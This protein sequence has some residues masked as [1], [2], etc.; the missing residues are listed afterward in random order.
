[1]LDISP[2]PFQKIKPGREYILE[3]I[4]FKNKVWVE[5]KGRWLDMFLLVSLWI[6]FVLQCIVVLMEGPS[7]AKIFMAAAAAAGIIC[8]SRYRK[9]IGYYE[10]AQC[11]IS[12]SEEM[13][14]WEYPEIIL[15]INKGKC[16]LKYVIQRDEIK[17]IALSNQLQ[18]VRVECSP[19]AEYNSG[20]K[21]KSLDYRNG[22]KN[23]ILVIYN[24]DLNELQRLFSRY[25]KTNIYVID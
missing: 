25:V 20:K 4:Q 23:C 7:F 6:Y 3:Q 17:S 5:K 1:M 15:P 12:F 16:S 8:I 19:V 18:S 10:E 24:Y 14:I 11:R 21:R 13:I 2:A 9:I 22:N